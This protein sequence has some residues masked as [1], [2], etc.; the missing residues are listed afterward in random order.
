M[1]L[2]RCAAERLVP[3]DKRLEL[4]LRVGRTTSDF[5][6]DRE[7]KVEG[8]ALLDDAEGELSRWRWFVGL[9]L[10]FFLKNGTVG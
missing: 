7:L 8:P 4:P 5:V 2:S 3:A 9:D 1:L 10:L 6:A